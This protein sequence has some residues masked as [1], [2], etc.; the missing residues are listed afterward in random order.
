MVQYLPVVVAVSRNK[1]KTYS[2]AKIVAKVLGTTKNCPL[3]SLFPL[4]KLKLG[5]IWQRIH[6][7][8]NCPPTS[9]RRQ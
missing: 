6:S 7:R 2:E 8:G 3:G 4:T 1:V 5:W 9:G